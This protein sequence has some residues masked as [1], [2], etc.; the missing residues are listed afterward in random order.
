MAGRLVLCGTPIGNL[1]DSTQ[2]LATALAEADVVFAE[3]TRRTST[4]LRHLGVERPM[5]SYFAGN[6]AQ[7]SS[8]L[9]E[10]LESGEVI[11]LVTDAGMPTVSDPGLSAVRIALAADAVVTV[12]P[13][14]SAVSAALAVSGLASDRFVFEGFLPRK[15]GDR[16]RRIAQ[17]AAEE[18]TIVLFSAPSR[19]ARDLAELADALGGERL[20]TVARELTKLHEEIWHGTLDEAS[21][22]WPTGGTALGEFTLVIAGANPAVTDPGMLLAEVDAEEAE[23]ASRSDAVR[24]VAR[25]HGVSRRALYDAAIRGRGGA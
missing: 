5:R 8:E 14:P 13:G 20:I 17:I 12:V 6:E 21:R 7:R 16:R 4:L 1:S 9:R 11:A 23:G 19:V 22:N 18:R 2:R 24:S 10:R 3:D 15:G 25:K